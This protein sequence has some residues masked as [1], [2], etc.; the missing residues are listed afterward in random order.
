MEQPCQ[1]IIVDDDK[2]SNLI[3]DF[4]IRR[5]DKE[6]QRSLFT[7][8]EEALDFLSRK[9]NISCLTVLLLD[10]NMP[11]MSGFEFLREFSRI[12]LEI[13]N[14]FRVYMLTS[15][16]EDFSS[17]AVEFPM[18]KRYFS[19]PLKATH[20]DQICFELKQEFLAAKKQK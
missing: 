1:Y 6:A 19:K 5:Y 16:I 7:C 20:L 9:G 13:K 14:Y 10:I 15:S 4:V 11:T 8:P 18:V 3:C 2:T 17:K 12:D